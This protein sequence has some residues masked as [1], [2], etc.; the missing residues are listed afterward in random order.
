MERVEL[1]EETRQKLAGLLPFNSDCVSEFTPSVFEDF[2]IQKEFHPVFKVRP[3]NY[4]EKK[5]L[6]AQNN[7]KGNMKDDFLQEL[8]RSVTMGWE[9]LFNLSTGEL[10]LYVGDGNGC[11]KDL[12]EILPEGAMLEIVRHANKLSGL[13]SWDR[14]GLA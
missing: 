12:F 10:V 13:A 14:L 1:N 11:H 5:S 8:A 9:N 7:G 6:R 2:G 3:Y 4:S